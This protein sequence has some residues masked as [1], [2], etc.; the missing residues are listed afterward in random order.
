[1]V[2]GLVFSGPRTKSVLS[3]SGLS[4]RTL[5][6]QPS[7]GLRVKTCALVRGNSCA[8]SWTGQIQP[9]GVGQV[10]RRH[11]LAV[12]LTISGAR[13][14]KCRTRVRLIAAAIG[15]HHGEF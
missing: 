15:E 5:F 8:K 11:K 9:H 12:D 2:C 7:P 14:A 10:A 1:M 3:D 4:R 6:G 13:K